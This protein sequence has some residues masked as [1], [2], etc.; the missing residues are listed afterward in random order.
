MLDRDQLT[1]EVSAQPTK[2]ILTTLR[3]KIA[4]KPIWDNLIWTWRP[5]SK[6]EAGDAVVRNLLL[7]WF[8]AK[9]SLE[10]L[11]WGYS[12]WLGTIS[13]VLFLILTIT[14]G[15]LMFLYVPSVERAYLSVKDLELT[16]FGWFFA[17]CTA[18]QHI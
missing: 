18:S 3:E 17:G 2:P 8:P 6:R 16:S 12:F 5:E 14:G 4:L 15:V 13:A 11:S 7:H 10:S 9:V 1:E